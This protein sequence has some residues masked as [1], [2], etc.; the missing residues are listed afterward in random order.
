M[1]SDARALSRVVLAAIKTA[2]LHDGSRG[3]SVASARCDRAS[4]PRLCMFE[5]I[6]K[7]KDKGD[8][9]GLVLTAAAA[10]LANI[11]CDNVRVSR[12]VG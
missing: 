12:C 8:D 7:D 10:V 9:S 11:T 6:V 1:L 3:S 2:L 5:Q 4:R